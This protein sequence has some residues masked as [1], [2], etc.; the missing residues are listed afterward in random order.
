MK[1]FTAQQH[2][3]LL[4]NGQTRDKDHFPVVKLFTPDANATWLLTEIEPE[5]PDIA[6]G[7][8]D[9]GHGFPELGNVYLPEL[10][11]LRGRLGLP[12]ER[13]LHFTAAYPISVYARAARRRSQIT[14]SA[15]DLSDSLM[16]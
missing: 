1:L 13:D 11:A 2:Q 10:I 8:C 3:Q 4:R 12:I 5:E 14:T 6:F 7:L 15:S 16:E 9:L